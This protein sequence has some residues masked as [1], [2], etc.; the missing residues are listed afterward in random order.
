MRL[1]G[2]HAFIAGEAGSSAMYEVVPAVRPSPL[3]TELKACAKQSSLKASASSHP[4]RCSARK[5]CA[6]H[7]DGG[8][9]H[10][11]ARRG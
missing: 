1:V 3:L 4:D 9:H 7:D 10:G 8:L 6:G 5:S 11:T 2:W